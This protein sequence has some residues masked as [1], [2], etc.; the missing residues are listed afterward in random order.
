MSIFVNKG[1]F[2]FIGSQIFKHLSRDFLHRKPEEL[3]HRM[4]MR[5]LAKRRL[6]PH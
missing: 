3:E 1:A 4:N 2:F 6:A 5:R